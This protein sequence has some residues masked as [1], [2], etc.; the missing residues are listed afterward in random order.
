[1]PVIDKNYAWQPIVTA[2]DSERVMVCGWQPRSNGGTAA[3][4][5]Y[6]EDV[7]FDG[8]P[9]EKPCALYWAPIVIP[10]FPERS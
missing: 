2:P 8:I 5:W 10:P 4:W 6:E 9:T 7:T 1:M 3:Y